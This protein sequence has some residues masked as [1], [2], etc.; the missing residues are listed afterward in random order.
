MNGLLI[1]PRHTMLSVILSDHVTCATRE[2]IRVLEQ[3]VERQFSNLHQYQQ[4]DGHVS[5]AGQ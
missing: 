4:G 1:L 3:Q 5:T 2:M